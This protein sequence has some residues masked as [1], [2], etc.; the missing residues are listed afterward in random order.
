MMMDKPECKNIVRSVLPAVRASVATAMH[1]RY[2]YSQ[3]A[4]AERLGVV[5]VAVSKYLRGKYS[6]DITRL[7]GYITRNRLSDSIVEKIAKGESRQQIDSD[8]DALCDRLV[9]LNAR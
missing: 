9:V 3:K 6:K 7:K 4:I 2:G 8:I 5:Q 1:E